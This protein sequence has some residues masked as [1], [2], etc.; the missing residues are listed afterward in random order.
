MDNI[1][2]VKGIILK[3]FMFLKIGKIKNYL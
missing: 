2:G 1:S 3:A